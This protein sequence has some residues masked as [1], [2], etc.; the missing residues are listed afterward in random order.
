MYIHTSKKHGITHGGK[1]YKVPGINIKTKTFHGV[2]PNRGAA[3]LFAESYGA[4]RCG[5]YVF[6]ILRVRCSSVKNG[7]NRTAPYPY[8]SK[9]LVLKD[10]RPTVRFAAD[11]W[12]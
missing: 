5:F 4:V 6:F 1:P 3:F 12:L 2:A 11:F 7:K 8:R 9:L 10:P